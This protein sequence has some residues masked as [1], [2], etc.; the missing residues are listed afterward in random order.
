MNDQHSRLGLFNALSGDIT[1]SALGSAAL[2]PTR[3]FSRLLSS[4]PVASRF[5]HTRE[6]VPAV[7]P[8]QDLL[9]GVFSHFTVCL[10]GNEEIVK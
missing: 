9:P 7:I 10:N 2:P 5:P 3:R 1:V 8:R 4:Y 6:A